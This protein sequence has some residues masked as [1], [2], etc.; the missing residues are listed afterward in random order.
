MIEGLPRRGDIRWAL[1]PYA[2]EEPF[3]GPDWEGGYNFA[4][5]ARH[6]SAAPS[7]T[8]VRVTSTAR[9]RPVLVLHGWEQAVHGSYACLR[10]RRLESLA[11]HSRAAVRRG[12][13]PDL[14]HLPGEIAGRERAVLLHGISRLHASALDVIAIAHLDDETMERVGSGLVDALDL[15][16][17]GIVQRRVDAALAE[18]G[19]S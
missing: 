17:A 18:L 1:V 6:A 5:V 11:E 7:R 8:G 14:L 19:I 3:V 12:T 4:A 13:E 16:V 15:D 10:T 2:F 9:M